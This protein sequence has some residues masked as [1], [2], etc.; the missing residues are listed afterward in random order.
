MNTHSD[1]DKR[2]QSAWTKKTDELINPSFLNLSQGELLV[3]VLK[4]H[5]RPSPTPRISIKVNF[6][7]EVATSLPRTGTTVAARLFQHAI[8]LVLV[9]QFK[10][11]GRRVGFNALTIEEKTQRIGLNTLSL[12]VRIKDLVHLG[13]LLNL[14]KH[15]FTGLQKTQRD[16]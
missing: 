3:P 15:L 1:Q 13:G 5:D 14:E 2:P 16:R 7:Q 6:G 8:D 4:M 10:R 9:V 11:L 12:G